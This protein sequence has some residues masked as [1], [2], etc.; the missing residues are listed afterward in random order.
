MTLKT[1]DSGFGYLHPAYAI[2]LLALGM[3]TASMYVL[4]QPR[5]SAIIIILFEVVT[6]VINPFLC[7]AGT[8][9]VSLFSSSIFSGNMQAVLSF[10][11][12]L[13][14]FFHNLDMLRHF[15][16]SLFMLA[17]IIIL[18]AS[19]LL[20]VSPSLNIAILML[21]CMSRVLLMLNTPLEDNMGIVVMGFISLGVSTVM[22]F[23]VGL[24]RGLN[25]ISYRRL[26]FEGDIKTVAVSVSFALMIILFCRLERKSVFSNFGNIFIDI[27]LVSSFLLIMLLTVARG[28]IIGISAGLLVFLLASRRGRF[29]FLIFIPIAIAVIAAAS[30]FINMNNFFIKRLFLKDEITGFNGRTKIWG[31]YIRKIVN[32]GPLRILFGA[33]PGN[34]SRIGTTGRYAHS[35][36]LDFFFSYGLAGFVTLVICEIRLLIKT[37]KSGNPIALAITV[38]SI[39]IFISHGTAANLLMFTMQV[40]M[41]TM[42]AAGSTDYE[43]EEE[44][45]EENE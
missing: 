14:L 19:Y 32:M 6:A 12:L 25:F 39:V 1:R 2:S 33:G 34:I 11:V 24:T 28:A 43:A 3:I 21:L 31:Y 44:A 41:F 36:F 38:S 40:L 4:A 26:S 13:S 22:Y 9:T 20:G 10:I 42:A 35:T 16:N 15:Q 23:L 8:I 30:S 17:V 5:Y 7:M 27:V 37:I 29:T 18:P 45:G